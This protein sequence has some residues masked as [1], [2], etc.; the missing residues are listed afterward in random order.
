MIVDIIFSLVL[1]TGMGPKDSLTDFQKQ[2]STNIAINISPPP[3]SIAKDTCFHYSELIKIEV[4]GR[5]KIVSLELSDSAPDWLKQQ[6]IIHKKDI[7]SKKLDSIAQKNGINNCVLLFPFIIESDD[8]PC[9]QAAQKRRLTE[10]YFQFDK[11]NLKGNM[12]FGDPIVISYSVA[13]KH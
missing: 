9:G 5:Y 12:A 2:L 8:F 7:I 4:S 3:E 1:T 10:A 6:F 13:Y 11:K